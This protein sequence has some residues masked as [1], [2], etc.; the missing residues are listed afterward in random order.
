MSSNP[1]DSIFNFEHAYQ[2]RLV[3]DEELMAKAETI[4]STEFLL[5]KKHTLDSAIFG[6]T[7]SKAVCDV[8]SQRHDRCPGHFAVIQLPFPIVRAICLKDFKT[9]LPLICPIC[10]HFLCETSKLAL[11]LNPENRLP[12]IKKEVDK[13]TKNGEENVVCPTC[14]HLVTV[15]KIG[16]PEP[17]LKFTV[18]QDQQ[19]LVDQI[20]PCYVYTILQNFT[21]LEEAGF[22]PNYHPKNFMTCL[23]PIIPNKLR[24]KSNQSSESTLTSYYKVIVEEI[25][26]ELAKVYKSLSQTSGM[27]IPY[28][29]ILTSFTKYYEKLISYYMLITDMGSEKNKD[30]ELQIIEKR[31][32][33]HVDDGNQLIGR[34]KGKDKSIF[35]KGIIGTRAN[36]SARTVLGGATDTRING[37]N[38]PYHIARKMHILYPV[39]KQNLKVMKQLLAS[40]SNPKIYNDVRIPRVMHVLNGY[41]GNMPKVTIKDAINQASTLKPGDKLGISLIDGDF[42][43]QSRFPAVREESWGSF[44]VN[45]DDNSIITIPL[46]DCDMKMADFDGDEAQVYALSS[47]YTDIESVLLH[48]TYQQLIAYK[49]GDPAIWYQWTN[50]I[51]YGIDKIKPGVK[52]S[53]HNSHRCVPDIDVIAELEKAIPKGMRYIDGKTDIMDGKFINGHTN[54]NNTEFTKYMASMY[55]SEVTE[56]FMDTLIQLAYDV[57]RDQGCTLGFDIKIFG[58]ENQQKIRDIVEDL[59]RNMCLNEQQNLLHK[60]LIQMT[61]V[62]KLK[63]KVKEILI[64]SAKGTTIDKGGY[65][66]KRQDEYYQTV[67]MC[68]HVII[69]GMRIKPILAEGSRVNSAFPRYSLDPCAYGFIKGGYNS[70]VSPI[71]HFYETKQQRASLFEKGKGTAKQGYMSKRLGVTYGTNFVDFNGCLVNHF[72]VVGTQ[73]GSCGLNPRLFVKQPLIDIRL[74]RKE[75]AA[76]YKSPR[77]LELYDSIHEYMD[78][79]SLATSFTRS[80]AIKDEF[81]A[82]FNYEQLINN[83]GSPG[84]TDAKVID[85]FIDRLLEIYAPSMFKERYILE[86]FVQHE[87]YFRVKLTSVSVDD[88]VLDMIYDQFEWSLADGGD[89]VGTKASLACSEPLTQASLHAIHH[90]GGGGVNDERL[91]RSAGLARFEE[92]LGGNK[93]KDTVVTFTLYDDS[94][95]ACTKWANEQETFYF[96][97]IWTRIE[98]MICGKIPKEILDLHPDINLEDQDVNQYYIKS[99]WNVGK[100]SDYD[101]H[102]CDVMDAMVEHYEDI[103]FITGYVL[104]STEFMAY[105]YFKSNVTLDRINTIIEEWGYEKESTIVHGKY[106]CNCYVSENKNRPGHYIIEANEV[107]A[108]AMRNLMMNEEVDPSG[109]KSTDITVLQKIYGICETSTRFYE[110]LIYTATNLSATSGVLHRHYKVLA[111]AAFTNGAILQASRNSLRKYRCMDTLRMIQF[112]T[113]RDMIQQSLKYGEIQP[114][115]DPVS[116]CVFGELPGCG[117]GISKITLY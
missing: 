92:L 7:T 96:N 107:H 108:E 74:E 103:L 115:A 106:L 11:K 19:S 97:S 83:Y 109:C 34:F 69:D 114:V 9:I 4:F 71:A 91:R 32:R 52:S 13:Y 90:A 57:N 43:M 38:V 36:I 8:C 55:G 88:K 15:I 27:S 62:E 67:V 5:S 77:V 22:S 40:M 64:S 111:D 51:P 112:E 44:Q 99:T 110:E 60:D 12:Y 24:I 117:T 37:I 81:I 72:R 26:P 75:F 87:Y 10:S 28:G 70:D 30:L 80:E 100:I 68:D 85:K 31:D 113:A 79:Y 89:P 21:Q 59:Y 50:D 20:N 23:I 49:N 3:D 2:L 29:D 45:K 63:V 94:K 86:N 65:T 6:S 14:K 105:I 56:N 35:S 47:H 16:S 33:K 104:N 84:S 76:K 25:C 102:V 78:R 95:E 61:E 17:Q 73:Y 66:K 48:S 53:I 101:I 1:L 98:L 54:C 116:A 39:Y 93:C 42:L 46:P 41:N 18:T 58:E 82:G